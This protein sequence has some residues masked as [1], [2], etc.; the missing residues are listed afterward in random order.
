MTS[1]S[2]RR[3][4]FT[5]IE[6]LTVIAIIGILAA[7]I[8]AGLPRALTAAKIAKLEGTFIQI[9]T[10]LTE[11]LVDHGT[12]PP[13]YGYLDR[14]AVT[15]FEQEL[16]GDVSDL[17]LDD[18]NQLQTGNPLN[19]DSPLRLV[20]TRPWMAF[21]GQHNNQDLHDNFSIAY[22]TNR[23]GYISRLEFSLFGEIKDAASQSFLFP[24]ELYDPDNVANSIS[25]DLEK[26]RNR[27]TQRPILYFPANKRQL[28]KIAS[29]WFNY[30][31]A[32][33]YPGNPRPNDEVE[34]NEV[35]RNMSFPPPSYDAYVLISAGPSA[36]TWGMIYEFASP[37]MNKAEYSP[38]YYYHILAMA[39]YFM[40]T[41]DA[42]LGGE[43]DGELDFDY[44]ARTRRGQSKNKDNNL[45]DPAAPRAAGP[46]IFVGEG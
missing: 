30:A 46:M 14:K 39:T 43:G 10:I 18:L 19:L 38:L 31:K 34:L 9:R 8:A 21:L 36:N 20:Y 24:G 12:F 16:G 32:D 15:F 42:E 23:D 26:Q 40:A 11:Y 22:D 1:P 28:R 2:K 6:L 41:R 4:G 25:I 7:L 3:R 35:L 45:P 17:S 44:R 13:A 33:G 37:L 27:Q 29:V 5:L